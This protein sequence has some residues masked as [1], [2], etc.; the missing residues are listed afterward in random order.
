MNRLLRAAIAEMI[1]T[2]ALTFVGA[3]A[4]IMTGGENL[5][6]IALAHG[7]I[8]GV[9]ITA[10]M[11]ISGGQ[12]NPAVSIALCAIGRQSPMQTSVFIAAQVIGAVVG[13][14][15]LIATMEAAAVDQ[16]RL[17]ATLGSFITGESPRPGSAFI[18]EV[19]GTFLLMFAVIGTA[20][21]SR[22]VGKGPMVGGFGIGLTLTAVILFIG[23]ATGASV[24]P[25]RSFGPALV[26]GHWDAHWLYWLAPII[27]ATLAALTWQYGIGLRD[28][29]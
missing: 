14:L 9:A 25:A 1:G 8:L 4:I 27:G 6:A 12:I 13:A 7:L 16:A 10:T 3:G 11:H 23:P 17:G 21:D 26:G 15:L 18:L 20:V 2:F 24:N 29:K 19:A 5:V 22:G 28:E